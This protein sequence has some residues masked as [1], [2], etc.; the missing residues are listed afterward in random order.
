MMLLEDAQ[1]YRLY[2]TE[3]ELAS[4]MRVSKIV[5]VP[6]MENLSRVVDGVTRN[7]IGIEVNLT[8]Y[9]VGAD[10]GGQISM[11]DQFDIDYNQQKY[12]IETR[13]CGAL[14]VP[15]SAIVLESVTSAG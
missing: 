3:A 1:G 10:K 14:A 12:L 2:K 8:D 7:L 6:I 4:A 15:Y 9:T 11:F 5:T 13:C